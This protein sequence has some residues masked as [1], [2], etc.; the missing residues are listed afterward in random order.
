MNK[1]ELNQIVQELLRRSGSTVT[2]ALESYF[3]GGRL[4]GGKYAM[5]SHTVTM[6]TEVIRQQCL[7]LF[8]SLEQVEAYF[9]VVFAHELGHAADQTLQEL[10]SRMDTSENELVRK[11]IALQ[12][13]ENAWHYAAAW[14]ADIDPAFVRVIVE[15]SLAA[16]RTEIAS[17]EIA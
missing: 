3:P 16:Y 8:G 11:Q 2:V 17:S 13:E 10:C 4:V 12:A 14:I 1:A 15:Q 9:A 6:Y 5:N 7:Q